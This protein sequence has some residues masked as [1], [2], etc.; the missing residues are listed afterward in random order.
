[1]TGSGSLPRTHATTSLVKEL[2]PGPSSTPPEATAATA[3]PVL[4]LWLVIQGRVA[5]RTGG[6][7]IQLREAMLCWFFPGQQPA[8]IHSSPD[9]RGWQVI[10]ARELTDLVNSASDSPV[11]SRPDGA[12]LPLVMR[13]PAT[14]LRWLHERLDELSQRAEDPL[15]SRLGLGYVLLRAWRLR[16]TA[17]GTRPPASAVVLRAVQALNEPSGLVQWSVKAL[18]RSL[19]VSPGQLQRRFRAE[20]GQTVTQYRLSGQLA[21]YLDRCDDDHELS[22]TD[23]AYAA[24]FG[25]YA[26]FHRVFVRYMGMSPSTHRARR[27]TGQ[28]DTT[29]ARTSPADPLRP[30]DAIRPG[31]GH[32]AHR[33]L[34]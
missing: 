15:E 24:G 9:L 33:G 25:S 4:E 11:F 12:D 1:M 18:A 21:R 8:P 5:V 29:A 22:I 16:L 32:A 6:S 20:T 14:D 13:I 2:V 30:A 28:L 10:A 7:V 34:A 19:D 3:A 17:R 23:A 26:Q 31:P 27:R